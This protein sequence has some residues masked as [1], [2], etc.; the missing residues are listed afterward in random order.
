MAKTIRNPTA[1]AMLK[2]YGQTTTTMRD[3]RDRRAK[4][5]RKSWKREEW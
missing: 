4:D 3:R 1:V 2:R 5:A